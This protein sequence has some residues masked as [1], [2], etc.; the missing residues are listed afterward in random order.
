MIDAWNYVF[1]Q[2]TLHGVLI[3]QDSGFHISG[4]TGMFAVFSVQSKLD[5]PLISES[6][7]PEIQNCGNH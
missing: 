4:T 1:P 6:S 5:W 3:I 7:T 2:L